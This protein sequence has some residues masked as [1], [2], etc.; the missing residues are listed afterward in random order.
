MLPRTIASALASPACRNPSLPCTAS[1]TLSEISW[2]SVG[3]GVRLSNGSTA[4]VLM[5]DGRPPPAKPY[6]QPVNARALRL[7]RNPRPRWKGRSWHTRV[8]GQRQFRRAARHRELGLGGPP[9]FGECRLR[10]ADRFSGVT[11]P[12]VQR[13]ALSLCP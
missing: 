12:S 2:V 6:R 3:S 7:G 4:T 11:H 5:S 1:R 9:I 13:P 8:E 10:L